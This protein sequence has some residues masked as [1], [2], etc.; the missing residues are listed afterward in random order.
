MWAEDKAV[1]EASSHL[2]VGSPEYPG[3]NAGTLW[4]QASL[5][6]LLPALRSKDKSLLRR[7]E[8]VPLTQH[9]LVCDAR[10]GK[11]SVAHSADCSFSPFSPTLA[12]RGGQE[13]VSEGMG[14]VSSF[15]CH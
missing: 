6:S 12:L 1:S 10:R 7:L 13:I 11:E 15:T 14:V 2:L 8:R 3:P 9:P 4:R 5:I